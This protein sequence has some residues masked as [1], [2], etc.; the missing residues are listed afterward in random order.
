VITTKK[1][2]AR[3]GA[4]I[5][6]EPHTIETGFRPLVGFAPQARYESASSSAKKHAQIE[7]QP[8]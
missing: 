8:T 2:G 7:P 3:I 1:G 6:S 4:A 5:D